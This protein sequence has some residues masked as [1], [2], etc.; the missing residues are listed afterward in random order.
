MRT[1]VHRL[2][3]EVKGS[4]LHSGLLQDG[5][6]RP[7]QYKLHVAH[8]AQIGGPQ[9]TFRADAIPSGNDNTM[10]PE[11]GRPNPFTGKGID[12]VSGI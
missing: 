3:K 10:G 4:G 6:L 2:K 7:L 5:P 12:A 1:L 11:G 8:L 9:V